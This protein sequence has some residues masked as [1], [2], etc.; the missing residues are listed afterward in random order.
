MVS[1]IF[2]S[3]LSW[4]L[5]DLRDDL[6]PL[7]PLELLELLELLEILD[8]PEEDST[9]CKSTGKERLRF[10]KIV[11]LMGPFEILLVFTISYDTDVGDRSPLSRDAEHRYILLT[12]ATA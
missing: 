9:R 7:D 5:L 12:E 6:D 11:S 8:L 1:L 3:S 10:L 4:R 2:R